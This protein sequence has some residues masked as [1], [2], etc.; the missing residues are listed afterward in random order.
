MSSK[1]NRFWAVVMQKDGRPSQFVGIWTNKGGKD[2]F[3]NKE[4]AEFCARE[5]IALRFSNSEGILEDKDKG[6]VD[7]AVKVLKETGCFQES[8][9]KI[10][11]CPGG[12]IR[13]REAV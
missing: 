4:E 7:E 3:E 9:F 13:E 6:K 5:H 10:L 2:R 12:S 8:G 1:I 11:I